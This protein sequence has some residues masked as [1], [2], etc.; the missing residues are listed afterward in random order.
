MAGSRIFAGCTFVSVGD[1]VA[2]G[3]TVVFV[4]VDLGG[5]TITVVQMATSFGFVYFGLERFKLFAQVFILLVVLGSKHIWIVR[6]WRRHL[7]IIWWW[8]Q[9][10]VG[11]VRVMNW[12]DW[13]TIW[14]WNAVVLSGTLVQQLVHD[15]F[16]CKVC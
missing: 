4:F 11:M 1:I 8:K 5:A 12:W 14:W 16:S 10:L 7:R 2:M 3:P 6:Q 15:F 9:H 13:G